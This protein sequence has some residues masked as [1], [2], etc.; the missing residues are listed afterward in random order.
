MDDLVPV[1]LME[2]NPTKTV[3]VGS[4]LNEEDH[5]HLAMFLYENM[6]VFAWIFVDIPSMDPEIIMH[7]LNI[8][9]EYRLIQQKKRSFAPKY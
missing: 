1:A 9:P 2:S 6:D 8:N 4:Y 3:Q 5:Q 7:Y